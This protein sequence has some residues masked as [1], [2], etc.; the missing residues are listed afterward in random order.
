[1]QPE[2]LNLDQETNPSCK[3][4]IPDDPLVNDEG[5]NRRPLL[6][7]FMALICL[8][9]F[10]GLI[11]ANLNTL[12]GDLPPYLQQFQSLSSEEIVKKS[13]P[14]VVKILAFNASP[15]SMTT[16]SRQGTGFNIDDRGL[17][18][19]NR[20]LLDNCQEVRVDFADGRSFTSNKIKLV[21]DLDLALVQLHAR[22][23]P[24][25]TPEYS[26]LPAAGE[27]LTIIGDPQG[28][29]GI[30]VQGSL[31]GYS[32]KEGISS[33]LMVVQ[34]SIAPG[35]S[36]SP[37]LDKQGRVVGVVFAMTGQ[38]PNSMA[39]AIPLAG[40]SKQLQWTSP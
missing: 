39:L 21:G 27:L 8:L 31:V 6:R 2:D 15:G 37:V 28:Y 33:G 19:T 17:V 7:R 35:N 12:L 1:M 40:L 26:R 9:A 20:H 25:L 22:D 5:G 29:Q 32:S 38:G 14:S 10:L 18:I 36:G 11:L 13:R 30:P 24:V 23:L 3:R 16:S 4:I 34:V